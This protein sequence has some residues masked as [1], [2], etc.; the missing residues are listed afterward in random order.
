MEEKEFEV[1]FEVVAFGLVERGERVF[2][3]RRGI[4]PIDMKFMNEVE[5]VFIE[6]I[7]RALQVE[8]PF[9]AFFG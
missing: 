8:E 7:K 3:G 9:K 6:L 1:F 5:L 4:F 2:A